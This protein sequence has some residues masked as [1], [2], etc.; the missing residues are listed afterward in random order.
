MFWVK[1]DMGIDTHKPKISNAGIIVGC[2]FRGMH[3]F[4]LL[5]LALYTVWGE[6]W[7]KELGAEAMI[8]IGSAYADRLNGV[9]E[10]EWS[11]AVRELPG[12]IGDASPNKSVGKM[13]MG[14]VAPLRTR[15]QRRFEIL[16]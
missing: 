7:A 9:G 15:G 14:A 6:P 13:R 16:R 8:K 12:F 10:K 2:V 4:G 1:S 3:L 5:A 11:H